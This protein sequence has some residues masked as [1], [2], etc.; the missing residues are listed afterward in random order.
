MGSKDENKGVSTIT[1]KKTNNH[2]EEYFQDH[3]E[4]SEERASRQIFTG[5]KDVDI[6][7]DLDMKEISYI[8]A[9]K[10]NDEFLKSRK[11]TPVFSYFY[12]NYLRLKISKDRKSRGEFVQ[13]NSQDKSEQMVEGM[14]T[15]GSLFGGGKQ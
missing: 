8:N 10:M 3:K 14:R 2:I 13:I 1:L 5:G 12:N 7:T 4:S 11:L 6:K 9:M 15:A